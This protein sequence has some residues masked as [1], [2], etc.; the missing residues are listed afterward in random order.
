MDQLE[1]RTPIADK[2][3]ARTQRIAARILFHNRDKPERSKKH[4]SGSVLLASAKAETA[5][6]SKTQYSSVL[7]MI[8]R[9]TQWLHCRR[10]ISVIN[11]GRA[12]RL[13]TLSGAFLHNIPA[14]RSLEH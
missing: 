8:A 14:I 3:A 6:T 9:H 2:I 12:H 7:H 11:L 5:Q 4:S 1:R 10:D 13:G